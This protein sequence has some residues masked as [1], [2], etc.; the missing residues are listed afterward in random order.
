[1]AEEDEVDVAIVDCGSSPHVLPFV[2]NIAPSDSTNYSS[3]SKCIFANY[4]N[5]KKTFSAVL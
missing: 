3:D 1:M 2:L 4:V 5:T